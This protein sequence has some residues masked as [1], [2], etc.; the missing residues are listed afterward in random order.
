MRM[1]GGSDG[2]GVTMV[3]NTCDG[4]GSN[5]DDEGGDE[6]DDGDGG[7]EVA[8]VVLGTSQHGERGV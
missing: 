7:G 4:S 6:W 5:G 3:K 1:T 2:G 8:M